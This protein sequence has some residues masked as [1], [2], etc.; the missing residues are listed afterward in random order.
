MRT[1]P[2]RFV[3]ILFIGLIAVTGLWGCSGT[4]NDKLEITTSSDE[5]R[6]EFETGVQMFNNIRFHEAQ[7][8]F[9]RAAKL[10]PEFAQAYLYLALSNP[11]AKG[12]FDNIQTA[13]KLALKA[14]EGERLLIDAMLAGGNGEPNKQKE[15]L[16]KLAGLYPRDECVL[17]FLAS[18]YFA[19][20]QFDSAVT[21]CERVVKIV[22]NYPPPYNILGYSYRFLNNNEAAGRAFQEYIRLTPND[23]NPYDSY[24]ELL[25]HEGQF[26][27]AIEQYRLALKQ[28]RD[29]G[30]SRI[31]IA[32]NLV[33][34][35]RYD[36]ARREL[37]ILYDSAVDSG[38]RR[39]AILGTAVSYIDEG[40]LEQGLGKLDELFQF[41][42]SVPDPATAANDLAQMVPVLTRLG[43][44]QELESRLA[45]SLEIVDNS[46]L[47]ARIKKN[48]HLDAYLWQAVTLLWQ[49]NFAEARQKTDAFL[50][51]VEPATN[52]ARIRNA[53]LIMGMISVGEKDFDRAIAELEQADPNEPFTRYFLAKTYEGKGELTKAADTYRDLAQAYQINSVNYALVRRDAAKKAA[54]LG[55]VPTP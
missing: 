35:G 43:R 37:Q 30:A 14:S 25:M 40:N 48:A 10:D 13:S 12:F 11:S 51:E 5:A 39:A 20:Q 42:S 23:P 7:R 41:D 8:H 33:Y 3:A 32:S 29:F 46:Q 52:A 45:Q 19:Q 47:F 27:K 15:L 6:R 17:M 50:S 28:D 38:Q 9:E 16:L 36:D 54:E 31:G 26:D 49:G 21:V 55:G 2:N 1:A 18:Q 34:L 4:R 24:A 53:Y 22:P 44:F